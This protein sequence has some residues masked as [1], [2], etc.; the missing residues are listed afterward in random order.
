MRPY[1]LLDDLSQQKFLSFKFTYLIELLLL[2]LYIEKH[3]EDEITARVHCSV[4]RRV[5]YTKVQCLLSDCIQYAQTNL[6]K[7]NVLSS[8]FA[9]F[10]YFSILG[11]YSIL[12][13]Y[14]VLNSSSKSIIQNY[15]GYYFK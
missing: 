3:I 10:F 14:T 15:D 12:D 1:L 9:R 5:H 11:Y 4:T 6:Q 7:V 13:S 2:A 8:Q